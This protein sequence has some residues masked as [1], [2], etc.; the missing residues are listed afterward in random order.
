M[1]IKA[2]IRNE[3]KESLQQLT[4]ETHKTWSDEIA[5]TLFE[6]NWWQES[7]VIA[8]TISRGKEVST[9]SIIQKAWESGKTVVVPK[10]DPKDYSMKFY[11]ITSFSQLET[12][13]FG[14][15]EPIVSKTVYYDA[16]DIDLIVVPGVVFAKDGYRIGYGGGYYDRY[17]VHFHGKKIALAFSIQ[18]QQEVPF[19]QHDIPVEAIVTN[20]GVIVCHD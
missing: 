8:L 14:L 17:L 19:E 1:N 9:T 11:K 15:K 5:N 4:S 2:S 10:C 13:Y 18:L 6:T 12:V 16:R 20:E 7:T 3:V